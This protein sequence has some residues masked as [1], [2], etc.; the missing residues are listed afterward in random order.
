M[1]F[2]TVNNNRR[3]STI[4]TV[5]QPSS[6][7]VLLKYEDKTDVILKLMCNEILNNQFPVLLHINNP[8]YHLNNPSQNTYI[9]ILTN[10]L[11]VPLLSWDPDITSL[12]SRLI[13]F[14]PYGNMLLLSP[15]ISLQTQAIFSILQRYN[16]SDISIVTTQHT[17]SIDFITSI[18][19]LVRQSRSSKFSF[20][21][22]TPKSQTLLDYLSYQY[23]L[24]I[25]TVYYYSKET[26]TI[27]EIADELGL[28]SEEYAWILTLESIPK[29]SGMIAPRGYPLGL[30]G[31]FYEDGYG[32]T[33]MESVLKMSV[34][35]WAQA[36]NNLAR[37]V[38]K[39]QLQLQPLQHS[40]NTTGSLYWKGGDVLYRYLKRVN[41]RFPK[42]IKFNDKGVLQQSAFKIINL[43][44][45]EKVAN[46]KWIEVG[47][48]SSSTGL[49]MRSITWMGEALSPPLGKPSRAYLR[50]ATLK[51][52]P[53]VN[54]NKMPE[55]G[56]GPHAVTCRIY[57]RDAFKHRVGDG[58]INVCCSG[59]SIDLLVRLSQDL[60][61][62]FD[63]F[64]VEDGEWGAED[65]NKEWNGLVKVLTDQKADMVVTAF[66]ISPDRNTQ[67]AF[68]VPYLET[69]ITIIVS[70]REGA[71]SPKAFLEPY[72]YPSWGLILVFSVHATGISIFVFEWLSPNGLDRGRVS[73]RDHKFSLFRS[74]WLI[75]AMLLSA[76]VSTDTPR[77]VSSRFLANLWALFALVFLA[78]YTANLAAF[79]ITKEEFYDLSGIGDWRLQNP[80]S[81]KPPFK[82]GTISQGITDSNIK[83]NHYDMWRY[84][85]KYN[86]SSVATA[87]QSVKSQKIHAFIYDA[88]VLEYEAGRDKGCRLRTVGNWYAMTGYGIGFPKN[89]KW[90]QKV[91]MV[92]LQLEEEGMMERLKRFWLKGACQVK[93]KP[94]TG[95]T[96]SSFSGKTVSSHT[97]GILNFTSAFILLACGIAVG[98]LLHILEH[99][100]FRCGR[101]NLQK[102][103][104]RGFFSLMSYAMGQPLMRKNTVRDIEPY[105]VKYR[106]ENRA[107]DIEYWKV[108]HQLD[109]ALL[110]IDR[111]QRTIS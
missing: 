75:W 103:N 48:W 24:T 76:A 45:Q 12:V 111:L 74:F 92:L 6:K 71:I 61:F 40:C 9:N 101:Q 88:T 38:V 98:T 21:C 1:V 37:D 110:K 30:L 39:T 56:C 66:K 47:K 90:I 29:N 31:I 85:R 59:L 78:S 41:I 26:S 63:L 33:A 50:I 3:L 43:Q 23:V 99:F 55:E 83:K 14:N 28:V 81:L 79:M 4:R 69:G 108:Q 54:Y 65:V 109:F 104:D 53:Y 106:C 95:V 68:S 13:H 84:M 72:D 8:Y 82:F 97:L 102:A 57:P 67:V 19:Q 62:D 20:V 22:E 80:Q 96:K 107:C 60:N 16:W 2:K 18:R 34:D 70:I 94:G 100:Y 27:L 44:K 105:Y 51:E 17:G 7:V 52:E 46:H 77:S 86:Q 10:Y 49:T 58:T 87:I 93:Q 25:S 11:G 5:F 89:S 73:S 42:P 36:L 35:V 64:E 91:N 32:K 15:S